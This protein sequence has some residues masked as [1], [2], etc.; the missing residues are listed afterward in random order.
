MYNKDYSEH[1][2]VALY[3]KDNTVLYLWLYLE[4]H[5]IFLYGPISEGVDSRFSPEKGKPYW[6]LKKIT[7]KKK[8]KIDEKEYKY[9]T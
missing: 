5:Y 1:R 6:R 8:K 7:W 2:N 9:A 4:L 3:S